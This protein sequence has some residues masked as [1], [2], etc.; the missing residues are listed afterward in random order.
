MPYPFPERDYEKSHTFPK[1]SQDSVIKSSEKNETDVG[2][3]VY[4]SKNVF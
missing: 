4:V 3:Y 2:V 1:D